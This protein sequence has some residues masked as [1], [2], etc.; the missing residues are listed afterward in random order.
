[1][2]GKFRYWDGTGWT[3]FLSS[4]PTAPPPTTPYSGQTG[5]YGGQAGGPGPYAGAHYQTPAGSARKGGTAIAWWLGAGAVLVALVLVIIW[6]VRLG[7]GGGLFAGGP[8]AQPTTQICPPGQLDSPS[9]MPAQGADGRVHGGKLS[10]PMLGEPFGPV[11][12]ETEVPFARNTVQQL[13]VVEPQ[14]NGVNDWVAPVMVG[15]LM[16]G[17]GFFSPQDGARVVVDCVVDRFYG[18][19]RVDRHDIRNEAT[20]IDGH[21]AWVVESELSFNVPGLVTD[22]ELLIIA[23]VSTG[24]DSSGIF[25][26]SIPNTTPDLVPPAREAMAGLRVGE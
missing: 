12:Q 10:Y 17:D 24:P 5:P 9:P 14:Y 8:G 7:T 21:D 4:T 1:M 16:A 3:A 26:A 6:A 11:M 13:V 23:I 22:G 2:P 19:S 15:D 25:Y 18:D 20:T